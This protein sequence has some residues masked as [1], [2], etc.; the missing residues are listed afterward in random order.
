MERLKRT[1][2]HLAANCSC[3]LKLN[4]SVLLFS[5]IVSQAG[6]GADWPHWRGPNRTDVTS[7]Q[8]GWPKGWPPKRL[9]KKNV[10]YGCTSPILV[11]G[12]L[13][14]MGWKGKRSGK[15]P[16]G[17]DTVHCFE[18]VTGKLRWKRSYRCRYQGRFR[19]GDTSRYGGPTSTLT[20][21]AASGYLYTLSI[22][23]HLKCWNTKKA[24][25]PVWSVS[26]YEKYKV[27]Q[28]P[29]VEAGTRD[30]GYSCSPVVLGNTVITEVGGDAGTLLAFDKKTGK[31]IW[32]SASKEPASH[33]A[34]SVPMNVEGIPCLASFGIRKLTVVRT[35]DRH[36]GETLVQYPWRTA[37]ACN[38][39]T[40]AVTDNKV[41]LSSGHDVRRTA[42]LQISRDKVRQLWSCQYWSEGCSPVIHEGFI[43]LVIGQI[44]CL[45]LSN[46]KLKWRGGSFGRDSSC[47]VTGDDKLLVFGSGDLGLVEVSPKMKRYR[48]LTRVKDVIG[49]T[50]YPHLALADG[51]LAVKNKEGDVVCLS[52]RPR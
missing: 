5:L 40:P 8:S 28:R 29:K 25:R 1:E 33:N 50:C 30:Y 24:G 51:I 3:L 27:R 39:I 4:N 11:N 2:E 19:V 37:F 20:F 6:R 49:G 35:D 16:V 45:H 46:G 42:L 17:T 41:V 48:E 34:G 21:D 44:H 14:V 18:A 15:N 38:I 36:R 10:G 31:Q 23:G 32:R 52:L 9:W 47:L 13:Y 12:R 43:Y 22:D 7:E 26:L